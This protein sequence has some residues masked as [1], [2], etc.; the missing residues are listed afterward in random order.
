MNFIK[1][2]YSKQVQTKINFVQNKLLKHGFEI[3]T[4]QYTTIQHHFIMLYALRGQKIMLTAV[5]LAPSTVPS[6]LALF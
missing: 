2:S 3:I 1:I 5:L 6:T 4:S